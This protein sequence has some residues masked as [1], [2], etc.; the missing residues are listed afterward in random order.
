MKYEIVVVGGGPAA[1]TLAKRLGK[2]KD[3][4]IIRPE[5]H[6]MIYCAMPYAIEGL[7][8]VE[9]TLKSDALVTDAGATLIRDR[10]E[11]IDFVHKNLITRKGET[12]GYEKLIL[13]TGAEPLIPPVPGTDLSGVHAFKSEEDLLRLSQLVDQGVSKAVVIGAGAIGVE[14]AQALRSRGSEVT[15]IDMASQVLPNLIDGTM[16]LQAKEQLESAGVE[17]VL[18]KRVVEIK[19][20][21]RV[22][23][24]LLDDDTIIELGVHGLLVFAVG[25]KA[26]TELVDPE[27]ITT[28]PQGIMVNEK[29]ESSLAGVF[30]VGDCTQFI[31]GITLKVTPG[32]LATNAVPMAKV[33][34]DR[35]LGSERVYPGFFNGAATKVGSLYFG[36]TGI[37][38]LEATEAAFEP[39]V[40]R[41]K[42]T[43]QFPI[44]P[45][46]GELSISLTFDAVTRRLI[47]AQVVSE[48]PVTMVIDLLT[49]AIQKES[50]IEDLI[51][52]SY[53]SQPYQSFY[54][55]ANGVVLAAE[56]V[57][58][59]LN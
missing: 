29:M 54:P 17:L 42:V 43:T 38:A 55:A 21:D 8:P 37:S 14:L 6:S 49:F 35:L 41:S 51:E 25:M 12:I 18:E 28:G 58:K 40:G 32:K 11:S 13:A 3:I 15:L 46:A 53:S 23:S 4:A 36:G 22:E 52:L 10:V 20:S 57:L 34:A 31:S 16:A 33:L 30:A 56:Q 48:S 47:G 59:A 1:I 27:F 7:L 9:K 39:V 2:K 24:V 45:D 44:M 5:A 19:G 26:N 50:V